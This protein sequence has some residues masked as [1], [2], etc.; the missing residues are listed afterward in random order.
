MTSP[1]KKQL[2]VH[3]SVAQM[4]LWEWGEGG[5]GSGCGLGD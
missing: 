3:I 4:A 1:W 5:G 2:T